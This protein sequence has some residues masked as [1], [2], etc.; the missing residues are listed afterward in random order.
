MGAAVNVFKRAAARG[1]HVSLR[2]YLPHVRPGPKI[3]S[4]CGGIVTTAVGN[5]LVYGGNRQN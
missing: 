5:P 4:G 3:I 2:R 1:M